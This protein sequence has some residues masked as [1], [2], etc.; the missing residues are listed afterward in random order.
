MIRGICQLWQEL[1]VSTRSVGIDRT[2]KRTGG[3]GVR[4]RNVWNFAQRLKFKADFHSKTCVCSVDV[5]WGRGFNPTLSRQFQPW[6]YGKL[7]I[8]NRHT[9]VFQ[10]RY[11]MGPNLRCDIELSDELEWLL[12]I[13]SEIHFQS[14]I[15][16]QTSLERIK[17]YI[18]VFQIQLPSQRIKLSV[19]GSWPRSRD[20]LAIVWHQT[21]PV[22]TVQWYWG[23]FVKDVSPITRKLCSFFTGVGEH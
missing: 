23:W 16:A 3:R 9:P 15:S 10:K 14:F 18:H 6:V 21:I 12:K 2:A 1:H 11:E 20:L 22:E 5:N 7:A 13:I 17:L 19:K 8:R 4:C